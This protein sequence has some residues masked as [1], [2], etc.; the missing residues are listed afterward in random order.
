MLG[1]PSDTLEARALMVVA[2]TVSRRR[3]GHEAMLLGQIGIETARRSHSTWTTWPRMG[4]GSQVEGSGGMGG[5]G[6]T[7]NIRA[8]ARETRV[9]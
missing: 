2:D 4:Q 9:L 5:E 8:A 3:F 1:I 6:V 7:P